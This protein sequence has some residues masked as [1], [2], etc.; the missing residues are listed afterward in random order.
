MKSV[1]SKVAFLKL[2]Q[3]FTIETQLNDIAN[4]NDYLWVSLLKMVIIMKLG[5]KHDWKM[6]SRMIILGLKGQP[7]IPQP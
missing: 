6:I 4:I 5:R 7:T 2:S 3:R 1:K